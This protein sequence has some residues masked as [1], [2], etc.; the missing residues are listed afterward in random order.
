M[1]AKYPLGAKWVTRE[2]KLEIKQVQIVKKE[3]AKLCGL[4]GLVHHVGHVGCVSL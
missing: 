2:D 1:T 3:P 4:R